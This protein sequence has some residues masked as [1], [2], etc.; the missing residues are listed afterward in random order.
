MPLETPTE[1]QVSRSSRSFA[2]LFSLGLGVG[3]FVLRA[4]TSGPAYFA[5]AKRHLAAIA[6]HT[7]IIQP[8]GYW[9]FNRIGGLFPNPEHGLL[10]MNWCLSALGCVAFYGCA[11][12]LV[13][14]PIAEL[15]ALLYATVFFAWFSGNIHSTYASQLL[16]APLTFYLMLRYRE[17][18]RL[19]WLFAISASFSL[20]AGL[21]P[22]DGAFLAPLLMLFA[23]RLPRR[24]QVLLGITTTLLCLAWL[25]PNQLAQHLYHPK[26][27][28]EQFAEVAQGAVVL[29]RVNL[30]TVSNALRFFLPLAL[31]LGPSAFFLFRGRSAA[32]LL[33]WTWVVPG[34]A[35]FLLLSI[36]DAPY[37]DCVL[38]G[39]LLLCMVGMATAPRNSA[40]VAALVGSIAL[41]CLFYLEFRPLPPRGNTYAVVGKDL[42]NISLYA[43]KHQLWIKKLQLRGSGTETRSERT[44]AAPLASAK[45]KEGGG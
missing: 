37:L 4:L 14:A 33:L 13:R 20:G 34:S 27:A 24:H 35:F 2:L 6:N 25:V 16:F 30:Y 3:V 5:D 38:G 39:F 45:P 8:P 43:V 41:N 32:T 1:G 12:R 42:G 19:A 29:G 26:S 36:S 40:A 44:G 10:A 7:Y 21:R 28:E 18:P 15:G 11:R 31:A 23:L 17:N 9:L 22:S